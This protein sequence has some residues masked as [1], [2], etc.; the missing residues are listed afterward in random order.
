MFCGLLS[1]VAKLTML[2]N[3]GVEEYLDPGRPRLLYW[4]ARAASTGTGTF[5]LAFGLLTRTLWVEIPA[6]LFFAF[7]VWVNVRA[8]RMRLSGEYRQ[9]YAQRGFR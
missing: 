3:Y 2:N 4:I 5:V 8:L 7:V 1:A 9:W 6:F